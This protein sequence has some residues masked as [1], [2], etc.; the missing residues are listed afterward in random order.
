LRRLK[1]IPIATILVL[2]GGATALAALTGN[3][4]GTALARKVLGAYGKLHG[5]AYTEKGYFWIISG[6][7]RKSRFDYVG[8][9]GTAPGGYVRAAENGQVGMRG[10][11]VVWWRDELSPT[12]GGNRGIVSVEIVL[13][14]AGKFYAF[15]TAARH[16]CFGKLAGPLPYTVGGRPYT[17]T[18]AVSAPEPDGSSQVLTYAY[19]WTSTRQ[20]TEHDTVV[21]STD[22]VSVAKVGVASGGGKGGFSINT[23]FSY[24]KKLSAPR[25]NVCK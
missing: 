19:P 7:G 23:K 15:G 5:Y 3:S 18:G 22:L 12:S 8:G 20:A 17:I 25:V 11:K 24:P 6:E 1:A 13:D 16:T 14:H 10:G 2:A 4:Q 21:S 9:T